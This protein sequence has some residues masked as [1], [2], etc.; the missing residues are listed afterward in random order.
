MKI[1]MFSFKA[2]FESKQVGIIYHFTTIQGLKSLSTTDSLGCKLFTF[3]SHNDHISTS[4]SFDIT[5]N[6]HAD[7]NSK[8]HPVRIAFDGDKISNL[9]KVLPINGL[10]NTDK[11]IFGTNLNHLRVKHKLEQ[12]EVICPNNRMFELLDYI[13][14]IQINS[15]FFKPNELDNLVEELTIKLKDNNIPITTTRKWKPYKLDESSES[16][17]NH[18][19]TNYY[20]YKGRQEF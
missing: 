15:Y 7:L 2:L 11:E 10:G 4:R 5:S 17:C 8:T 1:E 18:Q 14:E 3:V 13:L 20:I 6:P 12:E 9:F 16:G 19:V